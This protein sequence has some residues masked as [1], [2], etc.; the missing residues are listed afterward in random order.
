MARQYIIENGA[1]NN[2]WLYKIEHAGRNATGEQTNSYRPGVENALVFSKKAEAVAF[3]KRW[4]AR[5]WQLKNGQPTKLVYE[6]TRPEGL[7]TQSAATPKGE[8]STG[9]RRRERA[10][11]MA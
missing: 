9:R 1:E 6:G 4:K 7:A 2:R 3:A 10:G 5:A 8:N 11:G